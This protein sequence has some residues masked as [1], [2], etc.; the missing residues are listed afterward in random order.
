MINKIIIKIK[1]CVVKSFNVNYTP[2]NVP[3]FFDGNP[4][5]PHPV[6]ITCT[7]HL[8]ELEYMLS[9]D[10][11]GKDGPSVDLEYIGDRIGGPVGDVF[12]KLSELLEATTAKV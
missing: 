2:V 1:K 9:N 5:A 12:N 4:S 6:A 11:G 8:K 3:A 10:W 7:I